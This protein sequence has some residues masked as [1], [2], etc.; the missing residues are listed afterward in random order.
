MLLRGGHRLT[1]WPVLFRP[2]PGMPPGICRKRIETSDGDFLDLDIHPA[3][4][5]ARGLV[6]ISHGLEGDSRRKY[7][8]GMAQ[9]LRAEGFQCLAWNMRSCSG[10]AN[11]TPKLYNMADTEDLAQVVAYA[12]SLGLPLGLVGFSMGGNQICRYLARS[13]LPRKLLA[14]C[15]IS[16]PGDLESV[17]PLLDSAQRRLYLNYFLRGMLRKVREKARRFPDFPSIAGID[18]LKS[19]AEFDQRF[20]AKIYGFASARDYWRK[21]STMD[22]LAEIPIPLYFLLAGDDPFCTASCY[23]FDAARKNN[24]LHLEVPRHGGHVGFVQK[25]KFYYSEVKAAKFM[26]EIFSRLGY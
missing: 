19:F 14:A 10:E 11:R 16:V 22:D 18:R 1:L 2:M 17:A 24:M 6:I 12:E 25:G 3:F 8:L 4:S 7:I 5:K 20:T 23:P 15:V 13:S 21:A 26:A 9:A